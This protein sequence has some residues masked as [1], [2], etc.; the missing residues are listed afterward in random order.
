MVLSITHIYIYIYI[1]IYILKEDTTTG[2]ID[3]LGRNA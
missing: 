1:Y 3:K 2:K